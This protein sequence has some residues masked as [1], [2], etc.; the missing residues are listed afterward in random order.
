MLKKVFFTLIVFISISIQSNSKGNFIIGIFD[1]EPITYFEIKKYLK[2][3]SNIHKAFDEYISERILLDYAEKHNIKPNL[4]L[5]LHNIELFAERLKTTPEALYK[6]K[7]FPLIREDLIS[8]LKIE[9]LK[10]EIIDSNQKRISKEENTSEQDVSLVKENDDLIVD[11]F[12]SQLKKE[13]YIKF[14]E[15]KI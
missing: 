11:E 13:T 7:N 2:K 8:K 9:L 3:H 12:I 10:K 15:N 1:N 6:D 4:N 14:I 5:I